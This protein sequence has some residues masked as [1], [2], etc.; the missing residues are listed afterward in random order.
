MMKSR[1]WQCGVIYDMAEY[2]I[3]D[4]VVGLMH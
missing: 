1:G 3:L 4:E 2:N